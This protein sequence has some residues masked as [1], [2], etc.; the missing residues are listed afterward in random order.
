MSLELNK[1]H[2]MDCVEGLKQLDDNSIDLIVTSPPYNVGIDYDTWKDKMPWEDYLAWCKKWL[3]ECFRV[4]K[5]DGRI[6][7]NHY[8]S[9]D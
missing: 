4:L 7:I 8:I 9:Y 3:S 6:C 5:D 2:N 1:V